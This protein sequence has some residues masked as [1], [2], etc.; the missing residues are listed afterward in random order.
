MRAP[1]KLRGRSGPQ[2]P[3]DEYPR[4]VEPKPPRDGEELEED[5][6]VD[7]KPTLPGAVLVLLVDLDGDSAVDTEPDGRL[8]E[9]GRGRS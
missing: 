9:A 1:S 8:D 7:L 3:E 6:E 2:L 5:L 4:L